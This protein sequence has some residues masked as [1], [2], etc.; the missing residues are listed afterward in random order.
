V[1]TPPDVLSSI[2]S[3]YSIL[4]STAADVSRNATE[5]VEETDVLEAKLTHAAEDAV[6]PYLK[7]AIENAQLAIKSIDQAQRNLALST[8]AKRS[9]MS[10]TVWTCKH[11]PSQ[12]GWIRIWS[13]PCSDAITMEGTPD[14]ELT[15]QCQMEFQQASA[16]A[17]GKGLKRFGDESKRCVDVT[18]PTTDSNAD[19]FGNAMRK[20]LDTVLLQTPRVSWASGVEDALSRRK[21]QWPA[22]EALAPQTPTVAIEQTDLQ[23]AEVKEMLKRVNVKQDEAAVLTKSTTSD[24]H[25]REQSLQLLVA[26]R[27]PITWSCSAQDG[28]TGSM[29]SDAGSR[30]EPFMQF[31]S[32]ADQ[33]L[34]GEC[35][36]EY[37]AWS[38][39]GY[40]NALLAFAQ[41]LA[42]CKV[43]DELPK[44]VADGT[45]QLQQAIHDASKSRIH[46][47]TQELIHTANQLVSSASEEAAR[48]FDVEVPKD[49]Y[50]SGAMEQLTQARESLTN[51]ASALDD[52]N[53]QQNAMV[54]ER[55]KL[56]R[57][58]ETTSADASL[59]VDSQWSCSTV[60]DRP[61]KFEVNTH[62][63]STSLFEGLD[64]TSRVSLYGAFTTDGQQL[65]QGAFVSP[66]QPSGLSN[67]CYKELLQESIKRYGRAQVSWGKSLAKGAQQQQAYPEVWTAG[68]KMATALTE[69]HAHQV[70]IASSTVEYLKAKATESASNQRALESTARALEQGRAELD[71]LAPKI[72]S[73]ARRELEARQ[74]AKVRFEQLPADA[75]TEQ[76]CSQ[77]ER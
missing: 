30:C 44:T 48:N 43:I 46:K 4:H 58:A 37:A 61:I 17:Y 68:A 73:E 60:P 57:K 65:A 29:W 8:N 77:A 64:S 51:A 66:E 15:G 26:P 54:Q 7:G 42:N 75:Q 11:D 59:E 33:Q 45:G 74:T 56:D 16:E 10:E 67:I 34:S 32:S 1:Q 27:D 21:N 25:D 76:Q 49:N 20:M 52:A 2:R 22:I 5:L 35:A 18:D 50:I 70:E 31:G 47:E 55:Q 6:V 28:Q 39:E 36:K 23:V 40:G 38:A 13:K 14:G 63:Q 72:K 12:A 62:C 3:V 41:K 19:A 71:Q 24:V 69:T 9:G 53:A